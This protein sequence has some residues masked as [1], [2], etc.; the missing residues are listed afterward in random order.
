MENNEILNFCIKKGLLLDK[1][2]LNLFSDVTDINSV[3]LIIESIKEKTQQRVI[4]KDI[5]NNNSLLSIFSG[6]PKENQQNLEKLKIKL[7]L[8][9]EISK[10]FIPNSLENQK[11]EF[12]DDKSL[13][14]IINPPFSKSKKLSVGDFV[15]YFRNRFS[16]M[17]VFLQEHPELTNPISINK[18]SNNRQTSSLI[19]IVSSK[20]L[21]KNKNLIFEIEDLTGKIKILINK[22]KK[23][24]YEKAQEITLDSVIGFKGSGMKE[25]FFANDIIFPEIVLPERKKAFVEEFALFIGDLHI[26]SKTFMEEEFLKFINYLRGKVPGTEKEVSKIKYLFIVGD[27]ITG[28]GVY[29][30]QENEIL[31]SNLESHFEKAAELLSKIPKNIQIIF[32]PGNHDGVRLMEPQPIL[33]E[34]YAWPIFNLKNITLTTN[35]SLINIASRQDFGGFNVLMYH[36]FSFFYYADNISSLMIQKAAHKPELIM[37]YLLKN[38]HL[39][40]TH[41]STQ[42]FPCEKDSHIIRGIPDIFLAGHTHKSAVSYYNNILCISVAG[43]EGMTDYMEKRGAQPDFCKV[44]MLNLKTR[45]IK[46]LDFE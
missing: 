13:V 42:Y 40:P 27:L 20:N 31:F 7:G 35:P 34:K 9:I 17:R 3:K 14:K 43:W 21:T 37:K 46:I 16:E 41:A 19:G 25:I 28:V 8:N 29:P 23:E 33:D 32:C 4:T 30:G 36:G 11:K 18:L 12:Y 26:G 45:A 5:F 6:L 44:P 39:A 15:S 22:N 24:L 10:E 1:E 38:R 2:V